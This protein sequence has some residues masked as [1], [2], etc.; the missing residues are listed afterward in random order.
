M[1]RER[2]PRNIWRIGHL[3]ALICAG[4][5][6]PAAQAAVT[7][8]SGATQ[9][10]TCANGVCAP[11]ADKAV[12][13]AGDLETLLASGNVEIT[14]TGTGVQS[15]DI[16]FKVP[17]TWSSSSVL[18]L[19]ARKSITVDR[20]ISISGLAGLTVVTNDGSRKGTFEFGPKGNV[21]FANLA[22]TLSIDG[23]AYSLAG[24]IKTLAS[25]ILSNPNG[26][27][28]LANSYD[29]SGDG[30]YHSSPISLF[31]GAFEGLGNAISNVS[32]DGP[33]QAKDDDIVEGLIAEIETTGTVSNVDLLN[34]DISV[35]GNSDFGKVDGGAVLAG[36]NLGAL[37]SC[38]TTGVIVGGRWRR[39]GPE[40]GGLADYDLGTVFH[41]HSA[42]TV[43]AKYGGGGL[44]ATNDGTISQSYATGDV[45]APGAGGLI[46]QNDAIVT[47]SYATGH[48]RGNA[49]GG[50]VGVNSLGAVTNSY[51]TGS[52][53][54]GSVFGAG[55]L[56]GINEVAVSSSY[57]TGKVRG[58]A[59]S[60]L[61]GLVGDDRSQSGSLDDTY[62]DTDTSGVTN[63]SQGAGNIAN[64]PGITGLTTAQFQ[65]GLP[66]GFDP[67]VWAE[68]ASVNG[69][70]PYL[71]ANP[72]PRR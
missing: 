72:P 43:T 10:M 21:T 68:R 66:A 7:V 14:T 32:I 30:T 64:D 59:G 62:W 26:N 52:V 8:S 24:D 51:A 57:S 53:T 67:K 46:A 11:T 18:T 60:I 41:S 25:D 70:L 28:A 13:N 42:V 17:V 63:P 71:L 20:P 1:D 38:V 3:A 65:S 36:D 23:A 4:L 27:F 29:A 39:G 16:T 45:S 9:N 50:L 31:G 58:K 15:N 61:G 35:P 34:A 22:S 33:T 49:A 40:L 19:D 69:G 55:G 37:R 12:L 56:I 54:G 48:V 2:P 6:A 44:V 5:I 47:G